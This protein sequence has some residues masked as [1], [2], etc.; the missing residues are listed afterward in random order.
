MSDSSRTELSREFLDFFNPNNNDWLKLNV[1]TSIIAPIR[2]MKSSN[3]A[4]T[5]RLSEYRMMSHWLNVSET[6]SFETTDPSSTSIRASSRVVVPW[7][8]TCKS[9][10]RIAI[11]QGCALRRNPIAIFL[12]Y[13]NATIAETIFTHISDTR[14]CVDVE[15]CIY[16]T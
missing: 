5:V 15:C 1:S 11:S 3:A 14:C 12:N 8:A 6:R 10:S 13:Q 2:S 16:L 7:L 4:L 9:F